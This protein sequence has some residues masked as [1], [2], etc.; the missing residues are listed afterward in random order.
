MRSY[1]VRHVISMAR[2]ELAI[3]DADPNIGV[4]DV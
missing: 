3:L 2:R 1:K 4:R